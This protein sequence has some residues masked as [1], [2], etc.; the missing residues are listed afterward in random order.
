M[1]HSGSKRA[2]LATAEP[3][4]ALGG[5]SQSA[6]F[7]RA[8]VFD[9]LETF[10]DRDA[11]LLDEAGVG[12][13]GHATS[14]QGALSLL[15][16][17]RPEMLVTVGGIPTL[18]DSW[19]FFGRAADVDPALSAVVL[20]SEHEGSLE[21]VV[22]AAEV[23]RHERSAAPVPRCVLTRRECEILSLAAPG[24]SNVAIARILWVTPETV[25]FHLANAYRKLGVHGRADAVQAAEEGGLI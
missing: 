11:V 8:V 16:R 4:G 12:V 7:L 24:R 9:P 20:T 19:S 14:V 15:G 1:R 10:G 13:V 3:V 21:S 18:R 25:K 17:L 6:R 23:S 2:S 22:R 5:E